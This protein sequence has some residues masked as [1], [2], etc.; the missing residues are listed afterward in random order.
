[1]S[2]DLAALDVTLQAAGLDQVLAAFQAVDEAGAATAAKDAGTIPFTTPGAAEAAAAIS[3]A[4]Q[5]LDVMGISARSVATGVAAVAVADRDLSNASD[6][7]AKAGLEVEAVSK[8]EAIALRE[9]AVAA[10]AAAAAMVEA[11][12]ASN[13]FHAAPGVTFR[14]GEP[15]RAAP[16]IGA[17]HSGG[18]GEPPEESPPPEPPGPSPE[19]E[20]GIAETTSLYAGLAAQIVELIAAYAAYRAI[21]DA[22]VAGGEFDATI[23]SA[24]LGIAGITQAYGTLTDAQGETLHGQEALTAAF[25]I[26]DDQLTKLQADAIRV[27]VPFAQLA[28]LFRGIEGAGLHA[29]ATLD[30]I[31][32]LVSSASLAATALGTPYEQLNTTLV[33][34]LEGHV[35]VTNQLVAHLGLSNQIVHQW[36]QQG[37]LV[38]NLLTTFGKFSAIGE[39]VQGTW[40]GISTE[41]KN[42]FDILAGA[43][44]RPALTALEE[45]FRNALGAVVDLTTGRIQP[46]L[47]GLVG[48]IG[49]G[50]AN[51]AT[52]FAE[53]FNAAIGYAKDLSSW[54]DK[55]HQAVAA[56]IGGAFALAEEFGVVVKAAIGL[57]AP[58]EGAYY[59][60]GLV[61]VPLKTMGYL[62]AGAID[63]VHLLEGALSGVGF[64]I[65]NVIL[66][67]LDLFNEG[68]GKALNFIHAGL[69][70][71][72][73]AAGKD[74]E[75]ALAR[76]AGPAKA[77]I[78]AISTG[79]LAVD[80]FGRA[81]DQA[82]ADA[83]A[84]MDKVRAALAGVH[85]DLATFTNTS[86]TGTA[87]NEKDIAAR[88]A[89][90][91]E[92]AKSGAALQ[93][94]FLD[95]ALADNEISYRD[96]FDELT[97][98]EIDS[99]DKQ[100]KAKQTLLA[101]AK[102]EEQPKI[103]ADIVAL[104]N[105]RSAVRL[106]NERKYQQAIDETNAK[107]LR[108]I[109]EQQKASGDE[110]TARLGEI[111]KEAEAYDAALARE[112]VADNERRARVQ[113]FVET[114]T[115]AAEAAD[116][117]KT[118]ETQ[119]TQVEQTRALI[120]AEVKEHLLSQVQAAEQLDGLQTHNLSQITD[121]LN[122]LES[123]AKLLK[124]PKLMNAVIT[125][126]L[127]LLNED[128]KEL[129]DMKQLQLQFAQAVG[130][131]IAD[132][133]AQGFAQ[134]FQTG[135]IS[136]G[137]Q[138]FA[139][140]MLSGF[141]AAMVQFGQ[142][143]LLQSTL[144][145]GLMHSLATMNPVAGIALSLAMIAAG[146]A[147][148][149]A[150]QAAFGGGVGGGGAPSGAGGAQTIN[151][152]LPGGVG[153]GTLPGAKPPATLPGSPP[154][155]LPTGALGSV[156]PQPQ[157]ALP[158]AGSLASAG[159]P[160]HIQ[161]VTLGRWSPDM[162]QEAMRE[163]RL[164]MRRGL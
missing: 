66:T 40:R 49:A 115:E 38:E 62:L 113:A 132:G 81:W 161:I 67:P 134:A 126:R 129:T 17:F 32:Q 56:V 138:A 153:G 41:I 120:Q 144:M 51:V 45:G 109:G 6:I 130:K 60:T 141:G 86:G 150:A 160:M 77:V 131:A 98:T 151:I 157:I 2:L 85:G 9:Q 31:R 75:A 12:R 33:Q 159:P 149:A 35:R 83:S 4:T 16:P 7:L 26:A 73:I 100:I 154:V 125:L 47:S 64:L 121:E 139:D 80:Q 128:G 111:G 147:L 114:E 118:I 78:D 101:A 74:G 99:L 94:Q 5:L 27:A 96:Y 95:S 11:Q 39:Q 15:P 21:R 34:L 146:E 91:I 52:L 112:G 59:S 48:A 57:L 137:F 44:V 135:S 148:E 18:G 136:K 88:V 29:G 123:I 20:A 119:L 23:E 116:L 162:Q 24:R 82:Q 58:I 25:A 143:A 108:Y 155:M 87:G 133:V 19:E 30:Q 3:R 152:A 10:R 37:T 140:T 105:Q 72:L 158:A 156:L 79:N 103:Q 8:A 36:E 70:D 55:N 97:R 127:K 117:Q 13:A 69:G 145:L 46:A 93:K 107:V 65:A 92:A 54:I 164:A 163:I 142:A 90:A 22:V 61:L 42:A 63:A 68:L 89:A 84:A 76:I 1:M 43:A 53:G 28:D 104:E 102:P 71:G 50:L 124:D 14:G 110:F 122:E 106:E